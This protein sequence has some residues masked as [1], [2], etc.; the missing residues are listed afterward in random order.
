[1]LPLERGCFQCHQLAEGTTCHVHPSNS[2]QHTQTPSIRDLRSCQLPPSV[3]MAF[4]RLPLEPRRVFLPPLLALLALQVNLQTPSA[5]ALFKLSAPLVPSIRIP[6]LLLLTAP[7]LLAQ[8]TPSLLKVNLHA[9][10][11]QD[12]IGFLVEAQLLFVQL[13]A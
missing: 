11:K 9:S 8:L 3:A 1:M 6:M 2:L 10:A 4:K 12:S 7:V 5:Q 13:V